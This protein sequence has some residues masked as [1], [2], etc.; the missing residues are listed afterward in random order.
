MIA[1]RCGRWTPGGCRSGCA[2]G[3]WP[4]T[5]RPRPT[6]S[7]SPAAPARRPS[8]RSSS[9]VRSSIQLL[10]GHDKAIF[11]LSDLSCTSKRKCFRCLFM[12]IKLPA[13]HSIISACVSP[14]SFRA[15]V[16]GA[17]PQGLPR[18]QVAAALLGHHRGVT[19]RRVQVKMNIECILF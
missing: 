9:R 4:S 13:Q 12:N 16:E 5:P 14:F 1:G 7:T 2:S 18:E 6:R 19:Q 3:A 15:L 11:I 10:M 17:P 8:T